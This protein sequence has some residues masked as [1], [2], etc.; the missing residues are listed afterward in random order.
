MNPIHDVTPM[1]ALHF[2]TG[3]T[4]R[5]MDVLLTLQAVTLF[6]QENVSSH[7]ERP[8]AQ[9]SGGIHELVVVKTQQVFGVAEQ[10]FDVPTG[11]DML[12]QGHR[13]GVQIT[14]G[15]VAHRLERTVQGETSDDDLTGVEFAHARAD[16]KIGRASCRE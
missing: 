16:D 6:I 9:D 12:E 13:I 2:T 7:N 14:G 3:V 4:K 8:K 10:D 15:P 5:N 11:S 1:P